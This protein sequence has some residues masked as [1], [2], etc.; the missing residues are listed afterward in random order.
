M[1]FPVD[2]D[3]LI[4][5][6]QIMGKSPKMLKV[7]KGIGRVAIKDL[8]VLISGE[9]GT[10]K[11]LVA[12]AIHYN[13]L[14][15]NGPF[16][17]VSFVSIPKDIIEAELFGYE[18]GAFTGA[19]EKRTGKIEEAN[20]GTLFLDEI[21]EVDLKLQAKI[22]RFI[23]EKEF[24][25]LNSNNSFKADVRIIAATNKDMKEAV[26]NGKFIED[27]FNSFNHLHIKLPPLRERKEDI[28]PI[29]K[30]F[31]K[32]AIRKFETE[33]KELS[34]DA[35]DFLVRYEWPGNV[36]E[37]EN[38]IKRA[39][40]LSRGAVIGKKD[41]LLEDVGSYSIKE[42]LEEKLRRYLKEMTKL[43]NC[44]L[45]ETVLS[46]VESSLITIV[47]KET[48][49]NQLKAAKTL[50]INRNTLRAKIKKYKIRI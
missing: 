23:R 11:E 46:E 44:Y 27:L 29:A 1:E 15:L 5:P 10:Y 20:K 3:I 6:P 18:K 40:V 39:A 17:A 48:G 21:L 7:F 19:T 12:K 28:L 24:N 16:I 33:P 37:L 13:S 4:Q 42:F 2:T 38:T 32:E 8:A 9:S 25:P 45:Y 36:R 41:L 50:G 43:E 34:K 35:K 26:S 31:L 49:G 30:H 14:R 47:L 22:L